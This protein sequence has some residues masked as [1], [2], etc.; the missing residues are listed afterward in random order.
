MHATRYVYALCCTCTYLCTCGPLPMPVC[1]YTWYTLLRVCVSSCVLLHVCVCLSLCAELPN[2]GDRLQTEVHQVNIKAKFLRF[3]L[4]S[5]HGEFAALNRYVA[6]RAFV[7]P[8]RTEH[9]S[10]MT[11][12]AATQWEVRWRMQVAQAILGCRAAC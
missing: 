5:G 2:R 9:S 10:S 1:V 3:V 7:S 4:Q 12:E 8:L 11:R 6:Y